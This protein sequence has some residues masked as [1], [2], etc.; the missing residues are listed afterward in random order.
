MFDND[1]DNENYFT[2]ILM[3]FTSRHTLIILNKYQ[4][5]KSQFAV[6]SAPK[7]EVES[8]FAG[9][10]ASLSQIAMAWEWEWDGQCP[11][12]GQGKAEKLSS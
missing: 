10:G 2:L 4:N 6:R 1:N 5:C 3:S 9:G 8:Q 11:W 12:A 7:T